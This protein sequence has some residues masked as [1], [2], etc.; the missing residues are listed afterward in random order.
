MLLYAGEMG[1]YDK[2]EMEY[3]PLV[4]AETEVGKKTRRYRGTVDKGNPHGKPHVVQEKERVKEHRKHKAER[5]RRARPPRSPSPFSSSSA[6]K[7]RGIRRNVSSGHSSPHMYEGRRSHDYQGRERNLPHSY[8]SDRDEAYRRGDRMRYP[9]EHYEGR[10][11]SGAPPPNVHAPRD[12]RDTRGRSRSPLMDEMKRHGREGR[13]GR[14]YERVP[15]GG[16]EGRDVG[17]GRGREGGYVRERKHVRRQRPLMA[18]SRYVESSSEGSSGEEGGGRRPPRE[19]RVFTLRHEDFQSILE[20]RGGRRE[21]SGSSSD[22]SGN[23]GSAQGEEVGAG[24]GGRRV[25]GG[26]GS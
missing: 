5:E 13:E 25:D 2:V 23:S 12:H 8:K 20:G 9:K 16:G 22:S 24:D 11:G 18:E 4:K 3:F 1:A 21:G 19:Q 14:E 17:E 26:E 15:T 6:H 7:G 10:R